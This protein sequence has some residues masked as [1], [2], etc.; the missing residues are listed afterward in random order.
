M[1]DWYY[2]HNKEARYPNNLLARYSTK[3]TA[4]KV[5]NISFSSFPAVSNFFVRTYTILI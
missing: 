1:V 2:F 3:L 5:T 4:V